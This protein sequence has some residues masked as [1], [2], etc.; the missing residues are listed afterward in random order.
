[1]QKTKLC[2]CL[3]LVPDWKHNCFVCVATQEVLVGSCTAI[4]APQGTILVADDEYE[5][6]EMEVF[7]HFVPTDWTPLPRYGWAILP[8]AANDMHL[9]LE[10]L[11]IHGIAYTM[12][13]HPSHVGKSI[14]HFSIRMSNI[15]CDL[16]RAAFVHDNWA[17]AEVQRM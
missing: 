3:C 8:T 9:L 12:L 1:M 10:K 6:V 15:N 16:H 13:E 4:E 2:L 5:A 17:K 14:Q 11:G 7:D